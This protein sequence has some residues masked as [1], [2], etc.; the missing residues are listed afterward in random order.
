MTELVDVGVQGCSERVRGLV[1]IG[2][3]GM[4]TNIVDLFNLE[5]KVLHYY[6][7]PREE[8]EEKYGIPVKLEAPTS[9]EYISVIGDTRHKRSMIDEILAKVSYPHFTNLVAHEG[10]TI[11]KSV[12]WGHGNIIQPEANI[13]SRVK[14]GNHN[15]ICGGSRFGHDTKISN[16]CTF[17]PEAAIAGNCDIR[18]GVLVGLNSTVRP[19]MTIGEGSIIGAGAIISK[20]V[21]PN[22]VIV[23]EP[24]RAIKSVERWR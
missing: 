7:N 4:A 17:G 12:K 21:P 11:V 22:T 24:G 15:L 9:A 23:S 3:G 14:I 5:D 20:D 6:D 16:Y 8:G 1:V 19:G 13:Y 10:C 18:E 2:A